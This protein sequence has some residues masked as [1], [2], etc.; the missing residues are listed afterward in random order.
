MLRLF[1]GDDR[2]GMEAAVAELVAKVDPGFVATNVTRLDGASLDLQELA[3]TARSLP[4]LSGVRVIVVQRLAERLKAAGKEATAELV[5][6][7]RVMPPSTDLVVLEP[8]LVKDA[9]VH[10]L[11]A[12]A[13]ADGRGDVRGFLLRGSGDEL[14][15]IADLARQQDSEI[16]REAAE[17][18]HRR[19]GD[20][21]LRLQ[22][23]I[24][25]LATYCLDE[26]R[27]ETAH[28][29]E[30]VAASAESSVFDL[31][32]AIGRREPGR[33][34]DLAQD[35]LLRQSEPA[36]RL[37]V[38]VGRQFRLLTMVKD[39]LS[40][41][42]SPAELA[43]EMESPAW[44]VRRLTEQSRQFTM[45]DLEAALERTLAADYA[46]KSGAGDE[47]GVLLQLVAELTL[48]R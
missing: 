40:S 25:K 36:Q 6:A 16:T 12:L 9:S 28:V 8:E 37:L 18:L 7:L 41:R 20:D 48:G 26:G 31:V 10:P 38:M 14:R 23:E 39:L 2:V 19:V 21:A 32:E 42:V 1:Y 27:I 33:A 46:I 34:L 29:R 35:L 24:A 45:P 13:S 22:S 43:A 30:L 11:H 47:Q 44:L 15:W 4:F 5:A 17:E 3:M